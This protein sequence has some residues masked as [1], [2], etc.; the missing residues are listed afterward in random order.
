ML[1]TIISR[2]AALWAG[3]YHHSFS[4]EGFGTMDILMS[5]VSFDLMRILF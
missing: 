2:R 1:R 5:T 3:L 4:D